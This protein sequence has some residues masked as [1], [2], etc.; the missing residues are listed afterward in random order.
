M[1]RIQ[2]LFS[3]AGATYGRLSPRERLLVGV[4]ALV[5]AGFLVLVSSLSFS[6]A[7]ARRE[8]RIE[9]K[10]EQLEQANRLTANYR[11]AES[12]R[13]D[14]ERR[15]QGNKTKL[16]THVDDLAKKLGVEIGGITDKGT[17]QL[18]GKI[19]ESA[20]EVTFTRTSLDKLMKFLGSVE[21]P[22]GLVKVTRLQIRPR[23]DQPVIDAW[24]VIATYQLE[25]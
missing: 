23:T 4:T 3:E 16:F 15:L 19:V 17:Q 21:T 10:L 8:T 6:R 5:V 18:P 13:A 12:K 24:L 22:G 20:V 14:L 11:Q 7:V 2:R 1:N 25:T 9:A